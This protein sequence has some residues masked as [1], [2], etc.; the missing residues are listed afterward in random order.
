MHRGATWIEPQLCCSELDKHQASLLALERLGERALEKRDRAR[1]RAVAERHAGG[2]AE[3]VCRSGHTPWRSM[4]E[5]KGAASPRVQAWKS[6]PLAR[7]C[8][9]E[10]QRRCPRVRVQAL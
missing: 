1:G 7:P 6:R 3:H 8:V 9:L 5:V 2:I 4:Q 10:Q